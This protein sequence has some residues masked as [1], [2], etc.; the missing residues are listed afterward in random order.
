MGLFL[1]VTAIMY[2]SNTVMLTTVIGFSSVGII[3]DGFMGIFVAAVFARYVN[4]SFALVIGTI[5]VRI[6]GSG[7]VACGLTSEMRGVLTGLFLF[8]VLVYSANAGLPDKLAREKKIRE[9]AIAALGT[10]Q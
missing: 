5:T 10:Q 2:T 8:V 1:G 6:L 4:Y 7:L 9:N 3:M